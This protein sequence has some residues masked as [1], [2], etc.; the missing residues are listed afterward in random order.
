MQYFLRGA[1]LMRCECKMSANL[2]NFAGDKTVKVFEVGGAAES[3][4]QIGSAVV[5]L[6]GVEKVRV[7]VD[8][9][10]SSALFQHNSDVE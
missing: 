5:A 2:L 7:T 10:Y 3:C 1:I 9:H 8:K 6:Q 4:S